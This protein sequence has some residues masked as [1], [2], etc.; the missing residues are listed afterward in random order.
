MRGEILRE[1]IAGIATLDDPTRRALY[2]F[3]VGE[4]AYVS[5]EQAA[6][7]VKVALHVAKFHLDKLVTEGLLD[8]E[9]SRPSGRGGPG[10]GRP[11]KFYR[12]SSREIAV[13]LPERHYDLAA[14][15]MARAIKISQENGRSISEAMHESANLVG[16]VM[17]EEVIARLK[18]E[19]SQSKVTGAVS[20][21]LAEHG[22]EPRSEANR[23]ILANCPFHHLAEEYTSLVCGMNADLIQG[24]LAG[25]PTKLQAQ[26][27]PS[28]GRCCV[29]LSMSDIRS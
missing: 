2:Q 16:R 26:L 4:A 10:A 12:R 29:L 23:I 6:S 5:R 14:R 24:L 28:Q 25:I 27:E 1:E 22:Y 3:V 19:P 18:S 17:A 7:A 9:Y 13:T 8:V 15:V 11:T 20:E 21:V